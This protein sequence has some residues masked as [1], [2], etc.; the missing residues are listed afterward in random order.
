LGSSNQC[1]V[2]RR[3]SRIQRE[4]RSC[5][6]LERVIFG[7]GSIETCCYLKFSSNGLQLARS[8]PSSAPPTFPPRAAHGGRPLHE[9]DVEEVFTQVQGHP[10]RHWSTGSV[11]GV[12][13]VGA[14]DAS[15][16][17]ELDQLL[18]ESRAFFKKYLVLSGEAYDVLAL[19]TA[20]TH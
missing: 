20:H 2:T 17:N 13:A 8:S 14:V 10:S 16:T 12:G 9:G 11:A 3:G 4:D 18:R 6:P 5:T 1:K 19:W 7:L 15:G